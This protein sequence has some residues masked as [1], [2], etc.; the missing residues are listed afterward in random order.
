MIQ[1]AVIL[2]AGRGTRMRELT[3]EIPKPMVQVHGKPVLQYVVEGLVSSGVRRILIVI[4]YRKEVITDFFGDGSRF[5]VEISYAEQVTQN[6]TGKVVELAQPFCGANPFI[7]SYGDILLDAD[8]YGK[9]IELHDAEMLVTVKYTDDPTKGG[10]VYVNEA[11]ELTDLREKQTADEVTTCWY[12]A[13]VYAFSPKIFDYVARL[14]KS[15][16]G[17]YELTDAIRAMVVDGFKVKAVEI[18]GNWADV[19]DPE[20]LAQLNR[21]V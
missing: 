1:T 3:A 12:N 16:R 7:L 13:G 6:G 19:R 8:Y 2:A 5:G 10:A 15:P 18:K 21:R 20:V 17:E 11:F 4:G 14:E 9:L